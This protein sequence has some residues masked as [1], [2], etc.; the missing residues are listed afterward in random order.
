MILRIIH[1]KPPTK[2]E[3]SQAPLAKSRICPQS[4]KICRGQM[5]T[6]PFSLKN[7]FCVSRPKI[8]RPCVDLRCSAAPWRKTATRRRP[9]SAVDRPHGATPCCATPGRAAPRT[10][11]SVAGHHHASVPPSAAPAARGWR[12]RLPPRAPWRL[13]RRPRRVPRRRVGAGR[14]TPPP[15]LCTGACGGCVFFLAGSVSSGWSCRRA[16]HGA[17]PRAVIGG[18]AQP[19][20][21]GFARAARRAPAGRCWFRPIG[22]VAWRCRRRG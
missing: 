18:A 10:R 16:P 2:A 6:S 9:W 7:P 5:L 17:T 21:D 3:L 1:T 20:P 4:N 15:P 22:P 8:S 19:P 14:G 13:A 12:P 11:A